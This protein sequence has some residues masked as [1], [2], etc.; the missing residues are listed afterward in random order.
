MKDRKLY[1]DL[2]CAIRIVRRRI[3]R[4]AVARICT[5]CRE[6]FHSDKA[7]H[8]QSCSKKCAMA[9]RR[10]WSRNSYNKDPERHR[11]VARASN[12][13][14]KSTRPELLRRWATEAYR[15]RMASKWANLV[16]SCKWCNQEFRPPNDRFEF[17]SKSC[18]REHKNK[19]CRERNQTPE[20]R[21]K[22]NAFLRAKKRRDPVFRL[23]G[24]VK[25]TIVRA[26]KKAGGRKHSS[27]IKALPYSI[28][29]LKAHLESQF[30]NMNGFSWENYGTLWDID[31]LVPQKLFRYTSVDSK[32]FRDCWA[33][34]NLRPLHKK[35]NQM[36]SAKLDWSL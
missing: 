2:R 9:L 6:T 25:W 21:A 28:P 36:K 33:L 35:L 17:C 30:D 26:L 27:V 12:E 3:K 14:L 32:N 19:F 10:L 4:M 1:E 22:R 13:K 11:A 5:A 8:L 23:Q 24:I 18:H 16:K 7:L 34:S 31:H 20:F 15:K 29:Q